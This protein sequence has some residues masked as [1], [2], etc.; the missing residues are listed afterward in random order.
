MEAMK[1]DSTIIKKTELLQ[2]KIEPSLKAALIE[3]AESEG[4]GASARVRMLI[5]AFVDVKR[6]KPK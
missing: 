2:I 1:T 6:K 5:R 3:K 4:L